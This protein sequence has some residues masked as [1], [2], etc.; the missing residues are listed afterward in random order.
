MS[1][2]TAAIQHSYSNSYAELVLSTFNIGL[3][4]FVGYKYNER[5]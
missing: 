2:M 5:H 4:F 3:K 1:K